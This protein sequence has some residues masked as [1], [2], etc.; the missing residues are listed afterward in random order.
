MGR[1]R[2]CTFW[3]GPASPYQTLCLTSWVAH[4]FD[5][6]VYAAD[7][8]IRLPPGA[9]RRPVEDILDLG[10]HI[11]R[12]KNGFGAGSPSLHSNLFRY[13]LVERGEWWL[14]TDVVMLCDDL[15]EVD[16]FLARQ[17]HKNSLGIGIMRLPAHSPLIRAAIEEIGAVI[18]TATWGRTG[19]ELITR[20]VEEHGL[21]HKVCER[22]TAYEIDFTEAIKLFDPKARDEVETRL[23]ASTFV[24]LWNEIWNAIGFPQHMGPPQGSYLDALFERYGGKHMFALN[25]PFASIAIWWENREQRLRLERELKAAQAKLKKPPG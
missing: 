13:R 11:H 15:P 17:A 22:K 3:A 23:A 19:P 1:R 5:V 20:L 10:G 7:T 16:F 25:A 12:Y 24:H 18:E 9:E 4:G 14:D 6:V 8:D 2:F 21:A